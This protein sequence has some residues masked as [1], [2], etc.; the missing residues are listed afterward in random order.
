MNVN[1]Q[2]E[3]R[4]SKIAD[5]IVD[6]VNDTDGP[7]TLLQVEREVPGFAMNGLPAWYF[8]FHRPSGDDLVWGGITEAGE[9]ALRKIVYGRKVAIQFVTP[10]PYLLD[11]GACCLDR[12]DWV[13]IMLLPS[14]IIRRPVPA[15]PK[16]TGS[17]VA[18]PRAPRGRRQA[19][20]LIL[21]TRQP[22]GLVFRG[23]RCLG[24]PSQPK[25]TSGDPGIM[26]GHRAA[27]ASMY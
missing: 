27:N 22:S 23:G 2:L 6:L 13:P 18:C 17:I 15:V 10:L 9:A 24:Q 3:K 14:H 26:A 11:V 4:S 19:R 21:A 25:G 12:D 16:V 7:V 5:A 1:M 20:L 8:A